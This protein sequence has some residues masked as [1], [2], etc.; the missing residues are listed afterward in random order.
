MAGMSAALSGSAESTVATSWISLRKPS[1]KRGR[2]VRSMR[3]AVRIAFSLGR[4]SRR[5]YRT[6]GILPAA[7]IFSS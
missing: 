6:P 5:M 4:P 3:R 1:G 2:M 7:Y